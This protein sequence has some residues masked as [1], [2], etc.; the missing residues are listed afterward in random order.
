MIVKMIKP[1]ARN[2]T[3]PRDAARPSLMISSGGIKPQSSKEG[4][5]SYKDRRLQMEFQVRPGKRRI[6][7]R[8]TK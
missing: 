7:R 1:P 2:P 4:D 5:V 3:Y 6:K 8:G